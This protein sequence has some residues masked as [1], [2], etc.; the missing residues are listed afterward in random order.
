MILLD[1][2]TLTLLFQGHARV[3]SRVRSAEPDVATTSVSW[4][5]VMQRECYGC[6]MR[7][8]RCPDG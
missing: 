6:E 1:T 5:E 4:I 2:D 7:G 3:Q 8:L